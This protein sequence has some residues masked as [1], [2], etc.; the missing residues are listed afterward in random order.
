[1]EQYANA[2]RAYL[3]A[4]RRVV[5]RDGIHPAILH[6]SD[7]VNGT[8]LSTK[9]VSRKAGLHPYTLTRWLK[10]KHAASIYDVEAVLNVMGFTLRVVGE[11]DD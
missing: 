11:D 10:G 2:P 4:G 8:D 1:M 9:R 6:I 5:P 3:K 7:Y